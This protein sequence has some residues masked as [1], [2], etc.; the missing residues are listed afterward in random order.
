MRDEERNLMNGLPSGCTFLVR[1]GKS[2]GGSKGRDSYSSDSSLVSVSLSLLELWFLFFW[3]T[4]AMIW[5]GAVQSPK[6]VPPK[7]EILL[8]L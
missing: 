1:L 7:V 8:F 2:L 3:F 6:K 4:V 5:G